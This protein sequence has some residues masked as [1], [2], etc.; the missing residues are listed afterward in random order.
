MCLYL[1]N[2]GIR[3]LNCAGLDFSR[4]KHPGHA[5]NMS[6]GQFD[7][8]NTVWLWKS[9]PYHAY[10]ANTNIE[11]SRCGGDTGQNA[12]A[13]YYGSP[14]S[15]IF[16]NTGKTIAFQK[17]A[18]GVKHFLNETCTESNDECIQYFYQMFQEAIK[19]GYDT[20]QFLAHGDQRCGLSAIGIVRPNGIGK[21]ACGVTPG[22]TEQIYKTG[23]NA[24]LPCKCNDDKTSGC[25]LCR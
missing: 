9:P 10:D 17:H 5:Q 2:P 21:Y 24:E 22:S 20:I 23:W 12:S 3:D 25:L 13:W 1:R 15:G 18:D 14:G 11:V 7:Q 4:T 6:G 8:S 19:Q 16:I